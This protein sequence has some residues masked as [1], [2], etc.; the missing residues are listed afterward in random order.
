MFCD[1]AGHLEGTE[2]SSRSTLDLI[3]SWNL[4][5]SGRCAIFAVGCSLVSPG[6]LA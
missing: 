5:E 4:G 2:D 1:P 6:Y 3:L